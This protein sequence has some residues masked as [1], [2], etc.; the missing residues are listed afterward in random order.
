MF[1]HR[2]SPL[3]Y[4]RASDLEGYTVG[5]YGP[6]AATKA[7]ETLVQSVPA[8]KLVIEVDNTTLLRKLSGMRYGER[9]VAVANV[10]VGKLL[11]RQE[12]IPDLKV[13][14][15]VSKIE[16]CIGLSR[17][18]VSETQAEEFTA[19]L[20]R[21]LKAGKVKQIADKYGVVSPAH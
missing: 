9:A 1:A 7:A 21:L 8:T 20:R 3:T 5:A 19:A 12:N 13:A 11:I 15:V 17:K 2:A 10:D 14:G 16:Y 4:T 6:S 18:K